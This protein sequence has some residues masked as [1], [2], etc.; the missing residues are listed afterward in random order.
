MTHFDVIVKIH[1]KEGSAVRVKLLA[2]TV[3]VIVDAERKSFLAK[4]RLV[5][6]FI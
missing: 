5:V 1:A 3:A 4:T 2:C 6:K